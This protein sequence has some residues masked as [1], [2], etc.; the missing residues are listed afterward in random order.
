M[1]PLYI[2]ACQASAQESQA[3]SDIILDKCRGI[4]F[5]PVNFFFIFPTLKKNKLFL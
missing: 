5:S 3:F 4:F 1:V 2:C